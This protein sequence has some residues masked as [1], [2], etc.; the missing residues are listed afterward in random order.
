M[1][2]IEKIAEMAN[3]SKATVS[4]ALNNK[5]GVNPET[6]KKILEIAESEGYVLRKRKAAQVS[7]E[8]RVIHLI[9]LTK[10]E[11]TSI[12]NFGTSFFAELINSIQSRCKS[13]GYNLIYKSFPCDEFIS[14]IAK[15]QSDEQY[16]GMIIIGTYL[17][18]TEI[19]AICELSTK[20]VIVD[21]S[22]TK[23]SVN[24]VTTNNFMGGY[25]AADHLINLGHRNI[26]YISSL[27]R[28]SN[29]E[30]RERGFL[31]ALSDNDLTLCRDNFLTVNG[32]RANSLETLSVQLSELTN[33][34][35][36]FF[37]ENDY[38]AICL[39]GALGK[40]DYKIPNDISVV[41]F[42]NVPESN[43][44]SPALTTI[45]VDRSVLGF[46]SV[47]RLHQLI[48][49]DNCETTLNTQINV[50]LVIRDTTCP[51]TID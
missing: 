14:A 12:H 23:T 25:Q 1:I 46:A 51:I 2:T 6:R 44:I 19:D 43:I 24:A 41:G 35:S 7:L 16:D 20:M 26:G 33:M 37:C 32:Y 45:N 11:I 49:N 47:D 5:P 17:N 50:N 38:T 18:K 4:L 13:L 3:T 22:L 42:D 27:L 21:R 8:K 15:Q 10:P 48:T 28:V 30:E 29:L 9:A 40:L 39:I 34:P 36:A 31:K